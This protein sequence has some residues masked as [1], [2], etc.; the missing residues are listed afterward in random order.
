M[1]Q[2]YHSMINGLSLASD[3]LA[4]DGGLSLGHIRGQV[5]S[6][7]LRYGFLFIERSVSCRLVYWT[8]CLIIY[9]TIKSGTYFKSWGHHVKRHY[10]LVW[11]SEKCSNILSL[12][13]WHRITYYST[14]LKLS[15][16][17]SRDRSMQIL[18]FKF[19][20][21]FNGYPRYESRKSQWHSLAKILS[22]W[23]KLYTAGISTLSQ[24]GSHY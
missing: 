1:H 9:L 14:S 12:S 2:V 13:R 3:T 22:N 6:P 18:S 17:P 24:K 21:L 7:R 16:L 23:K 15:L 5:V 10:A 4:R 11:A 19:L 8:K 20:R